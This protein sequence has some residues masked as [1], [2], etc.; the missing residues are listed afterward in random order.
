MDFKFRLKKLLPMIWAV[1]IGAI[2]ILPLDIAAQK[3]V[4]S[5]VTKP[6]LIGVLRS[7]SLQ[8]SAMWCTPRA[9]EAGRSARG[10]RYAARIGADFAS[11]SV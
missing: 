11:R 9:V 10:F 8:M 5:P 3:Y 4:G 7:K 6:R 1:V 2:L